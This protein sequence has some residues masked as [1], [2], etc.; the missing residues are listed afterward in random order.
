MIGDVYLKLGR[1]VYSA[2]LEYDS[3]IG[4]ALKGVS[5]RAGAAPSSPAGA[6]SAFDVMQ[7]IENVTVEFDVPGYARNDLILDVTPQSLRL[8]AAGRQRRSGKIGAPFAWSVDLP[9]PVDPGQVTAT[10]E[11]GVLT[12]EMAK[13]AWSRGDAKRVPVQDGSVPPE[14]A[15]QEGEQ[16][17]A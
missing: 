13:A 7:T 15:A 14:E 6:R 9:E 1:R 11:D 12:V 2:G 4:R 10:L 17:H 5:R 8:Q 16:P 3:F